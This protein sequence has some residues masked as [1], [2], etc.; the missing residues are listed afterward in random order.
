[1]K[2]ILLVT[3]VILSFA[4]RQPGRDLSSVK[5]DDFLYQYMDSSVKAG[6]DFFKFATGTWMKNNPIPS[7]ER[8]WGIANLVRDDIYNQIRKINDESANDPN[9][10]KGSNTQ[11]IGDFWSTGMDSARI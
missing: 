11:K 3:I 10:K 4:C 9:A 7:S 6:D 2:Q 8:R 5:E 1:M